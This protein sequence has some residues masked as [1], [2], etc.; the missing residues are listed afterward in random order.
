MPNIE[1]HKGHLC[2]C[3][4]MVCQ[5]GFCPECMIYHEQKLQV[6]YSIAKEPVVVSIKRKKSATYAC[7]ALN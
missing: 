1:Y 5:E 6:E 4:P 3:Q 2:I 7:S